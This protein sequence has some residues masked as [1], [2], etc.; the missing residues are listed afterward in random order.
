MP[1]LISSTVGFQDV[2]FFKSSIITKLNSNRM[3]CA[4]I[5]TQLNLRLESL[6]LD[7]NRKYSR[8]GKC[9]TLLYN[10]KRL[11]GGTYTLIGPDISSIAEEHVI[12]VNP[13]IHCL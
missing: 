7:S 12:L 13:S 5:P 4:E 2:I 11:G 10:S 6:T 1:G 9:P 3:N 8:K